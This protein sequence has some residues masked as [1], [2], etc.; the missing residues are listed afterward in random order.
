MIEKILKDLHF[1]PLFAAIILR[2]NTFHMLL[3]C[4]T[5]YTVKCLATPASKNFSGL[6]SLGVN[7]LLV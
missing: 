3:H 7:S 1:K 6:S 4:Y 5:K 2:K